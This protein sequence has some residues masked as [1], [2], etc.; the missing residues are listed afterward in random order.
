MINIDKLIQTSL[1]KQNHLEV[2]AFR[3]VKAK[4]VNMMTEKGRKD[5]TLTDEIILTAFKREKKELQEEIDIV[6][7]TRNSAKLK[8]L[9]AKLVYIDSFI[10]KEL[11]EIETIKLIEKAMKEPEYNMG[12]IMKYLKSSGEEINMRMASKLTKDLLE[13]VG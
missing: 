12:S 13:S 4:I 11:D 7:P 5:R 2:S 9:T 3:N 10:P 6:F 1:K 8:A